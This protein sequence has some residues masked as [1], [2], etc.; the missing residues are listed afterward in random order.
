MKPVLSVN[1]STKIDMKVMKP[2]LSVNCAS[3]RG[4]FIDSYLV[5]MS[6]RAV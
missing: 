3:G 4:D 6:E 2:V 5:V 1:Y